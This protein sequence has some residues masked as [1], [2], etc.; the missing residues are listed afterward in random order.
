MATWEMHQPSLSHVQAHND[1]G[2]CG[3]ISYLVP[4]ATTKIISTTSSRLQSLTAEFPTVGYWTLCP[5]YFHVLTQA[6]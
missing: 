2:W 6:S 1:G 3:P 4:V 5:V